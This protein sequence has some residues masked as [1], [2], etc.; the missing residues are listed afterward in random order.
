MPIS[1]TAVWKAELMLAKC[2][3]DLD[4]S[5]E[6]LVDFATFEGGCVNDEVR[7]YVCMYQV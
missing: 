6:K 5:H 7:R 3:P 4:V 2:S 1:D